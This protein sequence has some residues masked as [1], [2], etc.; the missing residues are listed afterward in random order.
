MRSK[1][2]LKALG[3]LLDISTGELFLWKLTSA[4]KISETK[5]LLHRKRRCFGSSP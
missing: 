3:L 4:R 2:K 1:E 5:P